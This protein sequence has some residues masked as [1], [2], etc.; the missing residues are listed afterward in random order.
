MRRA[1]RMQHRPHE[2]L[3]VRQERREAC[4]QR[5]AQLEQQLAHV[6]LVRGRMRADE[7][8]EQRGQQGQELLVE[9]LK[10]APTDRFEEG[11]QQR[12]EVGG[13]R[14]VCGVP[15]SLRDD[16]GQ[17]RTQQR[18]VF[19]E[20]SDGAEDELEEP[21]QHRRGRIVRVAKRSDALDKKGEQQVRKG[22]RDR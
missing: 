1:Q 14:G 10:L 17:V 7:A 20:E 4:G 22:A 3:Q 19:R 13:L 18:L 9:L 15:H 2:Q 5:E 6:Q 8:L 11:A 16:R 12:E 21:E